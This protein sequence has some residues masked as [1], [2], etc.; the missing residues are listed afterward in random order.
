MNYLDEI[1]RYDPARDTWT[2]AGRMKIPRRMHSVMSL[3]DISHL[4]APSTISHTCGNCVFPFIFG[5]RQHDRCTSID[6]DDPWCVT[7][8]SGDREYCTDPSCPGLPGNSPPMSVHPLNEVGSCC[9]SS[10]PCLRHILLIYFSPSDCG[11]PNRA[12]TNTRIVGGSH[13]EVGEYPWQ[14]RYLSF[15]DSLTLRQHFY[16]ILPLSC[17]YSMK[18]NHDN[19]FRLH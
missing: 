15:K 11:I 5:G 4:C 9:K 12:E 14:V 2:A 10:V 16:T 1:V 7:S 18:F 17:R 8:S 13:T 19:S 3:G 6:G